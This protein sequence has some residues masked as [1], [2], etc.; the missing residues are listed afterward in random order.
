MTM[1]DRLPGLPIR[2]RAAMVRGL[3]DLRRTDG[4]RATGTPA[5]SPTPSSSAS[6]SSGNGGGVKST[7]DGSISQASAAAT[8][9]TRPAIDT[10]TRRQTRRSSRSPQ[11]GPPSETQ[12]AASGSLG[13][14]RL[15][16]SRSTRGASSRAPAYDAGKPDS[17]NNS[18]SGSEDDSAEDDAP[19]QVEAFVHVFESPAYLAQI[20][21]PM[22]LTTILRRLQTGYYRQLAALRADVD[23]LLHNCR[24]YNKAGSAIVR[25]GERLHARLHGMIADAVS[26]AGESPFGPE[27]FTDPDKAPAWEVALSHAVP[28]TRGAAAGTSNTAVATNGMNTSA[29]SS[30]AGAG[31]SGADGAGAVGTQSMD[32]DELL[33]RLH[34]IIASAEDLDPNGWFAEPVPLDV[35]PDYFDHVDVPMD[36][37][38][39]RDKA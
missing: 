36:L 32:R 26:E 12:A 3:V 23:L 5:A 24:T 34:G 19:L 18:S 7:V 9:S 11:D 4:V 8:R 33:A 1:F 21:V 27:D 15:L 14:N 30:G 38:T 25:V 20:P 39:I 22:C 35:A 2:F 16:Q 28:S 13:G 37:S 10:A 29:A 6:A 17:S 31:S